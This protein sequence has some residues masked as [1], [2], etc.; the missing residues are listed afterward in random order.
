M[1]S[2]DANGSLQIATMDLSIGGK[3]VPICQPIGP[4]SNAR[5]IRD[6]YLL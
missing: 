2:A 5:R 6:E 4:D 1:A 3:L